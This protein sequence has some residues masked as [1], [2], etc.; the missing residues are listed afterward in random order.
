M[1]NI[2][3]RIVNMEKL[4]NIKHAKLK[5]EDDYLPDRIMETPVSG[6]IFKGEL[7]DKVHFGEILSEYYRAHDW[8]E[9]TGIP[10]LRVLSRLGIDEIVGNVTE[11]IEEG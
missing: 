11:I 5:R 9:D 1:W 8:N 10:T 3:R 4:F 2:G 6:G 7:L